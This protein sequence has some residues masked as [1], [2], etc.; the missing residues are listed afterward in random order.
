MV[1]GR[2]STRAICTG[3]KT[4][5]LPIRELTIGDREGWTDYEKRGKCQG[6]LKN[7]PKGV[8]SDVAQLG[9]AGSPSRAKI[10]LMVLRSSKSPESTR[11]ASVLFP[12]LTPA[13]E[14][15]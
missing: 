3:G 8:L 9:V 12:S 1:H 15:R 4:P 6:E 2:A 13:E 5:L 7:A 11:P 10:A 14:P